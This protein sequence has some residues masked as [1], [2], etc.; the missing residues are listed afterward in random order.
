MDPIDGLKA[1]VKIAVATHPNVPMATSL[2]PRNR[3]ARN[4]HP[5]D[6]M[7]GAAMGGRILRQTD[8]RLIAAPAVITDRPVLVTMGSA[9][10]P[11]LL[12]TLPVNIVDL[13]ALL[14]TDTMGSVGVRHFPTMLRWAIMDLRAG[15]T[16]VTT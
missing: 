6:R 2:M 1:E 7:H 10:G 15:V 4:L 12:I 16:M 11:H 5:A 8:L 3:T 14:T 13:P 9:V